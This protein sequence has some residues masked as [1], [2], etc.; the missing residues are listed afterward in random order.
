MPHLEFTSHLARHI[1]APAIDVEATDLREALEQVFQEN[2]KLRGYLLDDQQCVRPHVAIFVD[3]ELM[4]DK[5]N[6]D[7]PLRSDSRVYVMQAL[8]GG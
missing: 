3:G 5:G 8:S 4:R 2:P 1:D 6:W 7:V